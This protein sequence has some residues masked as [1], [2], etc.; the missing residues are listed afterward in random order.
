MDQA[1][2][3]RAAGLGKKKTL[4]LVPFGLYNQ[5]VGR[6]DIISVIDEKL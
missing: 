5:F 3:F 1:N 4:F 2:A 6:E